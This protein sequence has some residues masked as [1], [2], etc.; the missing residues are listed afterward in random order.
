MAETERQIEPPG[1]KRDE[2]N[3]MPPT[4]T[5]QGVTPMEELSTARNEMVH[6]EPT[7]FNLNEVGIAFYYVYMSVIESRQKS[8]PTRDWNIHIN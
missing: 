8:L 6:I 5:E 4:T 1:D 7:S 2:Q 3:E